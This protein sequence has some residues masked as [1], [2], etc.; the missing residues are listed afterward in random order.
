M[1]NIGMQPTVNDQN[2]MARLLRRLKAI[3]FISLTLNLLF[4][5]AGGAYAVHKFASGGGVRIKARITKRTLPC[6]PKP[7]HRNKLTCAS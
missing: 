5:G 6:S 7:S 3:L 1:S 4:C 2:R